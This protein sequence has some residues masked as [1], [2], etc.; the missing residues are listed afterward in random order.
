MSGVPPPQDQALPPLEEAG[1]GMGKG[2][3]GGNQS[4]GPQSSRKLLRRSLRQPANKSPNHFQPHHFSLRTMSRPSSTISSSLTVWEC[5]PEDSGWGQTPPV[6]LT[7][8]P[9]GVHST[10]IL[11]SLSGGPTRRGSDPALP[12]GDGEPT[13][14]QAAPSPSAG[15][16]TGLQRLARHPPQP[17]HTPWS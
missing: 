13:S 10:L 9:L 3:G 4:R 11:A 14:L 17:H 8:S 2:C 1:Q 7:P 15:G 5:G 12:L 16:G 6:A